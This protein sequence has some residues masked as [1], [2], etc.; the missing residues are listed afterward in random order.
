MEKRSLDVKQMWIERKKKKET[1]EYFVE[2]DCWL[3]PSLE[4]EVSTSVKEKAT[5]A[6]KC[7]S[8]TEITRNY[9]DIYIALKDEKFFRHGFGKLPKGWKLL[10][11]DGGWFE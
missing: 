7:P 4:R 6:N 3:Q 2:L 8:E 5:N 11:R 10:I 9:A 1:K